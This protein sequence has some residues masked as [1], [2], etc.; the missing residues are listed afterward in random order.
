[1]VVMPHGEKKAQNH[2]TL[3]RV[4]SNRGTSHEITS[5]SFSAASVHYPIPVFQSFLPTYTHVKCHLSTVSL[6]KKGNIYIYIHVFICLFK[7]AL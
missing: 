6:M 2:R 4:M 3:Q 5:Q 7:K 1:M